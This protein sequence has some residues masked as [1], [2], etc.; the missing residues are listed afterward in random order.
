[1]KQIEIKKTDLMLIL[2]PHPDDECIGMGGVLS[3]HANHS[4][5]WVLSDGR[6]GANNI[7]D[8]GYIAKARKKEFETEM[9][10]LGVNSYRMFEKEDGS[11]KNEIEMLHHEDLSKYDLIFVPHKNEIH[12]DHSA[13]YRI[14]SFAAQKQYLHNSKI[15][16]YEITTPMRSYT[17]FDDIT[18]CLDNKLLCIGMH[19][20]QSGLL[21]YVEAARAL[22]SFR[23]CMKGLR[24]SYIEAFCLVDDNMDM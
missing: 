21:D 13:T 23:A 4:D 9:D 2:A 24:N 22:N 1:M 10:Y 11:L 15:Y 5:V 16:Q 12:P 14:L 18:S 19:K 6:Y 20:S 8:P 3:K 7:S 17:H